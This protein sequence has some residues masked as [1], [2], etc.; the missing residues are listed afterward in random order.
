MG[1]PGGAPIAAAGSLSMARSSGWISAGTSRAPQPGATDQ[2]WS[3]W[4]C[5]R[6][7]AT[8]WSLYRSRP[9]SSGCSAPCPGSIT[10]HCSP[11]SG[12]TTQQLVCQGPA[13][14]PT[15]STARAYRDR[16]FRFD[17][18]SCVLHRSAT[19]LSGGPVARSRA[20]ERE[21]ARRR[22]ERRRLR[23]QQ[24]RA[25][26]RRRNTIIGAVVGTLA[27]IG[28]LIALVVVLVGGSDN[29]SVAS[30]QSSPSASTSP[31]APAAPPAACAPRSPH[32]PP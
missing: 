5:D 9:S 22:Y 2:M 25:R 28:G 17:S 24:L 23:E 10:T 7:T 3:T 6:S 20:R 1:V 12:A 29:K 30:A 4:P 31:S 32:P 14:K 19:H 11:A 26:R 8:G 16:I 15:M 13:G 27:V 21:L 18:L